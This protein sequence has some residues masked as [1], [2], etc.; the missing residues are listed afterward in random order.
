M[1]Q[2]LRAEDFP[3][4]AIIIASGYAHRYHAF[5]RCLTLLEKPAGTVMCTREGINLE[6]NWNSMIQERP[7]HTQWV[8]IMGDDHTFA[9]DFL[10]RLLARQVDVVVPLCSLRGYP[11]LPVIREIWEPKTPLSIGKCST[12]ETSFRNSAYDAIDGKSGLVELNGYVTGNAGMLIR[13]TSVLE[14]IP[15]PWF[16]V[17]KINS[18]LRSSD[19]HFCL[20]LRDSGIPLYVD[21]ENTMGH[22]C[23]MAAWPKRLSDGRW[24]TELRPVG[25]LLTSER[26]IEIPR[27]TML[28]GKK[29]ELWT[30][31]FNAYRA[32]QEKLPQ[33]MKH[34]FFEDVCRDFPEIGNGDDDVRSELPI[35][36]M[37]ALMK[38]YGIDVHL[39]PGERCM[40][41]NSYLS[42]SRLRTP[43][44]SPGVKASPA[45]GHWSTQ[46]PVGLRVL[47]PS[48]TGVSPWVSTQ[49]KRGF[50]KQK[51]KK[52]V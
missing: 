11:F 13:T 16:E 30:G 7:P 20:K 31:A 9:P 46:A 49:L 10:L 6:F 26:S 44:V 33:G 45:G 48:A 23:E 27:S 39:L 2:D 19:L 14:K 15:Y 3:P 50:K 18:Q 12:A 52:Y 42:R 24:T 32:V 34:Q 38:K 40:P 41:E 28:S 5:D 51:R 17:G 29:A 35:E 8:F 43:G 1:T 25:D 47:I 37:E 36:E 21:T 4:G 22:I